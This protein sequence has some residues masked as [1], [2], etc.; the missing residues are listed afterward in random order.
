[1][2]HV[3]STYKFFFM[4]TLKGSVSVNSSYNGPTFLTAISRDVSINAK[5]MN[6]V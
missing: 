2:S 6:Y 3:Y 1:M 4:G 5:F